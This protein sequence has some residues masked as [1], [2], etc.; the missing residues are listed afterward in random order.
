MKKIRSEKSSTD[1]Y[2]ILLTNY[3]SSPLRDFEI[4]LRFIV[5]LDEDDIQLILKQYNSKIVTYELPA[6]IYLNKDTSQFVYTIGRHKGALRI[7]YDDV[8]METE[9]I[10]SNFVLLRFN[11]NSFLN[12]S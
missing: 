10:L 7:E 8:S 9:L 11:E 5:G 2:P 3:A 12:T 6:S 1:A 4:Y